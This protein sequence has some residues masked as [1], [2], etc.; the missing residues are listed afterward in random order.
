[1]IYAVHMKKNVIWLKP[2]CSKFDDGNIS[3]NLW[4]VSQDSNYL[5][6]EIVSIRKYVLLL[7]ALDG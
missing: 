6:V 3:F 1:M 4:R 5:K 7:P 2:A